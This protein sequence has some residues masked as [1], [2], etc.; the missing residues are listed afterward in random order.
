MDDTEPENGI[1]WEESEEEILINVPWPD[2]MP[3]DVFLH[4]VPLYGAMH[5]AEVEFEATMVLR[6]LQEGG[7]TWRPI[8]FTEIS[9]VV[10]DDL[11]D[12]VEPLYSLLG[13]TTFLGPS[14]GLRLLRQSPYVDVIVKEVIGDQAVAIKFNRKGIEA[15]RRWAHYEEGRGY[16]C[17]NQQGVTPETEA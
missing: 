10:L 11:R 12:K 1:S 6:A 7:N 4:T 5:K 16:A 8:S 15:M 9:D 3:K 17:S 13:V 2:F 14:S